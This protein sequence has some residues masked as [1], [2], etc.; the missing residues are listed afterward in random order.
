MPHGKK[1]QQT[2]WDQNPRLIKHSCFVIQTSRCFFLD[3]RQRL[4]TLKNGS[5][6]KSFFLVY[7]VKCSVYNYSLVLYCYI[8]TFETERA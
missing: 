4:Q 2:K 3:T 1:K 6:L 5:P 8:L 7:L